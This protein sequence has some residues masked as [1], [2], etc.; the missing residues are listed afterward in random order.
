METYLPPLCSWK[1]CRLICLLCLLCRNIRCLECWKCIGEEC[2]S[3]EFE[4]YS[5]K[6][7]CGKEDS[8]MKVVYEMIDYNSNA[9]Y[10][11]VV[12]MCSKSPCVPATEETFNACRRKI[13]SYRYY[14]CSIRSCCNS[15]LCNAAPKVFCWNS[16]IYFYLLTML[17]LIDKI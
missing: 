15:D 3:E 1:F 5:E 14:G 7:T 9:K 17:V 13:R 10:E 16:T 4:E 8:C 11:S 6:V 2:K 12:R